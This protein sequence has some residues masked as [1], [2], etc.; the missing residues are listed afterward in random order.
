MVEDEVAVLYFFFNGFFID[1]GDAVVSVFQAA[2]WEF[3]NGD[4]LVSNWSVVW[5]DDG[6]VVVVLEGGEDV[7]EEDGDAVDH[8]FDGVDDDEH[9]FLHGCVHFFS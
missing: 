2:Y 5:G 8:G 7:V 6:D 4:V 3:D 9:F 1:F